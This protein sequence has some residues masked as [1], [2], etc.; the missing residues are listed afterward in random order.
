MSHAPEFL[1]KVYVNGK[2]FGEGNGRNKK[3]AEKEAAA[4]AL[5]KLKKRILL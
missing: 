1:A 2:I 4:D 3:D 5:A